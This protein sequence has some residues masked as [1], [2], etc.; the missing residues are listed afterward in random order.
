M[1]DSQMPEL[2]DPIR[3]D[4]SGFSQMPTR[5]GGDDA[6]PLGG[7]PMIVAGPREITAKKVAVARDVA[8]IMQQL[9]VYCA[10]FG[11]NYVYSWQVNNR[12]KN[13]K[14][15]IEGGTIKLAN[16]LL[17]LYGNCSADVDVTETKTH[18]IFKAFFIDYE[19]GTCV[20]R[21]FQQRKQQNTGMADADRQADI[22]FQIGQ[23][24]AIR[25]VVLNAL[26]SFANRAIEW[27][28]DSLVKRF[29][30][31]DGMREKAEDFI[32]KVAER[33][34]I[35][36]VRI[37]AIVGRRRREWTVRD[38]AAVYTACRGIWDGL[39]SV[40]DAFPTAEDAK[41]LIEEE[42]TKRDEGKKRPSSD[43]SAAKPESS[44]G[45]KGAKAKSDPPQKKAEPASGKEPK[46][47]ADDDI[48]IPESLRRTKPQETKAP[49]PEPEPETE[50][51]DD[52]GEDDASS[53]LDDITTAIL[54]AE[55]PEAVDDIIHDM[56]EQVA[57]LDRASKQELEKRVEN[58]KNSLTQKPARAA[59]AGKAASDDF[60]SDDA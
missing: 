50:G 14:D 30:S 24:K 47:S 2:M 53:A 46:P 52:E 4:A 31:D 56:D 58:Y 32:D 43:A 1:S 27:S 48:S 17:Q 13:R 12:A 18:L 55:T 49:D 34:D 26:A 8:H 23:S 16:D 9:R 51:A 15:T 28:K 6:V 40:A 41:N 35:D 37:E 45:K 22:V 3:P 60:F 57:S 54:E 44:S 42:E 11:D 10:Q 21:L 59:P 19:R 29:G 20:S 7:A 25:N 33:F 38:L 39:T 5:Y 36:M